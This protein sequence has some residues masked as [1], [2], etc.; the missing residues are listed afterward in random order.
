MGSLR[1]DFCPQGYSH[2][3]NVNMKDYQQMEG[4]EG[5]FYKLQYIPGKGNG[6]VA[7]RDIEPSEL[8]GMSILF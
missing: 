1:S 5:L 8:L 2:E 6:L 3:D 7:T 4:G